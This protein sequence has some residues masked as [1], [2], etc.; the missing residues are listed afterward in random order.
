MAMS[1]SFA[2]CPF[3]N[4]TDPLDLNSSFKEVEAPARR[5]LSPRGVNQTTS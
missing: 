2:D 5:T 3:F 1:A 4:K